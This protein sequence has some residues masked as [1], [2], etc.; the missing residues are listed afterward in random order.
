M[1]CVKAMTK[2]IGH[3]TL[4]LSP[5][6][7]G[8]DK[9]RVWMFFDSSGQTEPFVIRA[10]VHALTAQPPTSCENARGKNRVHPGSR[11]FIFTQT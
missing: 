6:Y 7:L 2:S 10:P 1:G 5:T 11:V 3:V 4:D 9:T 8:S